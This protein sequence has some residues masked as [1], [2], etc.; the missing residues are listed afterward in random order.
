MGAVV[1][2]GTGRGTGLA[3]G[4]ASGA[5]VGRMV[6]APGVRMTAATVVAPAIDRAVAGPRSPARAIGATGFK[7]GAREVVN[8]LAVEATVAREAAG[9]VDG[10]VSG[11][12]PTEVTAVAA[13]TDA[14]LAA[15]TDP[16]FETGLVA[17]P[18]AGL[19]VV[20]WGP[21]AVAGPGFRLVGREPW[22][23]PPSGQ[24]SSTIPGW[25]RARRGRARRLAASAVMG[26]SSRFDDVRR[27]RHSSRRCVAIGTGGT[28]FGPPQ[29]HRI[30]PCRRLRDRARHG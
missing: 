26:A 27:T 11:L 3:A 5:F 2:T 21:W 10:P 12:A 25:S 13:E 1:G 6:G 24:S 9:A 20:G 7:A 19:G 29:R 4:V 23:V 16:G 18:G 22:R 28:R 17:E 15:A 8:G 14:G 30:S